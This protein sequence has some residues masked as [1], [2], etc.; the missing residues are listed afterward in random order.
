MEAIMAEQIKTLDDLIYYAIDKASPYPLALHEEDNSLEKIND[1]TLAELAI[2]PH[3]VSI[4]WLWINSRAHH[5]GAKQV[6]A[7]T[8]AKLATVAEVVTAVHATVQ[9]TGG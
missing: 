4:M 6:S 5:F 9:A 8:A 7:K 3:N 1:R 2:G